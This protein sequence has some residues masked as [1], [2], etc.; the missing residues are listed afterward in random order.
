[1]RLRFYSG[2]VT[3]C[4]VSGSLRMKICVTRGAD[5][6]FTQHRS[7]PHRTPAPFQLK[8]RAIGSM[9]GSRARELDLN[10]RS[11]PPRRF[12]A[13]RSERR[14]CRMPALR[15][16]PRAPWPESADSGALQAVAGPRRFFAW[17]PCVL[18]L[19]SSHLQRG[20]R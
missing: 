17:R 1:M 4:A 11:T 9:V 15:H 5:L 6:R 12:S 8:S 2:S 7:G 16:G 14:A 20:A 10:H 19:P 18:H 13:D 3:I